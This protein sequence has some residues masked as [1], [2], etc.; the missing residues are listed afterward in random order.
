MEVRT[1]NATFT[2]EEFDSLTALKKSLGYT[3]EE[4]IREGA[5]CLKAKGAYKTKDGQEAP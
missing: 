4:F 2:R 5:V 1:I 3:W